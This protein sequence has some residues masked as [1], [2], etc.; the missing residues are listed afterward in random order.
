[1]DNEIN[2]KISTLIS[3]CNDD[4]WIEYDENSFKF[5]DNVTLS[6]EENTYDDAR[7]FLEEYDEMNFNIIEDEEGTRYDDDAIIPILEESGNLCKFTYTFDFS[8][9]MNIDDGRVIYSFVQWGEGN[10][11]GE[12]VWIADDVNQDQL[13]Q[14]V[15]SA[16][17]DEWKVT[18]V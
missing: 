1:M 13:S 3:S 2:T 15:D 10:V 9:L 5:K 16:I 6:A 14:W 11:I 18:R 8:M 12:R 4:S 7:D 17:S